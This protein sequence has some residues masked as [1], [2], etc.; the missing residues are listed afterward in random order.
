MKEK[1]LKE[2]LYIGISE[3]QFTGVLHPECRRESIGVLEHGS[4]HTQYAGFLQPV[5]RRCSLQDFCKLDIERS[6]LL[7]FCSLSVGDSVYGSSVAW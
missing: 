1:Q 2:F 7:E 6:S 4:S 3:R 5:C